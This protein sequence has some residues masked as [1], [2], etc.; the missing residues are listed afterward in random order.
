MY[1]LYRQRTLNYLSTQCYPHI[2]NVSSSNTNIDIE[3]FA[4]F[5]MPLSSF[6]HLSLE[7]LPMDLHSVLTACIIG[8]P[9]TSQW[10]LI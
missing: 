10:P 2:F 8:S 3:L 4:I 5:L 7:G 6:H 1:I 9:H